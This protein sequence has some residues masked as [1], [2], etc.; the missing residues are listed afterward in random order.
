[1]EN[2][3]IF[4]IM[5]LTSQ[6]G[7]LPDNVYGSV[8]CNSTDKVL[9]NAAPTGYQ[10]D[11]DTLTTI[12]QDVIKQKFYTESPADFMPVKVGEGAFSSELLYYKN[13]ELAGD[14]ESGIMGQGNNTRKDSVE[15]GYDAIRLKPYFWAKTLDYSLIEVQQAS[16]NIGG[17]INIITQK[18]EARKRNWDL[19]IQKTAFLGISTVSG[20][21]GLL[22]MTGITN[23]LTVITKAIS[24]MTPAEINVVV[25]NMINAYWT[26]NNKTARPDY[27]IMPYSD[28]FG[29]AELID[30]TAAPTGMTKGDFLLNAFKFA[31]GNPN[32]QIKPL[33]YADSAD[34]GLGVERYA[35]YKNDSQV[36]EMNIPIDFTTTT[37]GTSNNFDF[38]SVAYG[39]FTGVVAKRPKEILYFS[40]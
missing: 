10:V 19:G 16:K 32:F 3:Q 22:N 39:Q 37:V 13:F 40:Y 8:L 21:E 30:P 6:E 26:N 1:M 36:L 29:L 17:T 38:G 34:N 2:N 33:Q 35:L 27:F 20:V 14:F 31:S 11:I 28:Y 18:E 4:N 24:S 9:S 15:V 5:A 23:N 12:K 25:K 7:K